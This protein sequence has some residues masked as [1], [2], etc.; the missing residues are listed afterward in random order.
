MIATGMPWLELTDAS[1]ELGGRDVLAGVTAAVEPGDLVVIVGPNGAGK[2]TLLRALAGLISPRLGTARSFDRD[3]GRGSRR[4]VARD[5][6]YL[7]QQYDLAFPFV[8]EEVVL[9][10]RYASQSGLGL[11]S[12][13]DLAAARD[14]M[15]KCDVLAL[16]ERR[17]D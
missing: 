16:A 14:A 11:A 5:L 9:F 1:V 15:A 12:P 4:A 2:T 8:V 13:T 17:F 10:G 6:A 3:P 7:P